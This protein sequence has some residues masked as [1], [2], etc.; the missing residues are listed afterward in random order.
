MQ[1]SVPNF[2][3]GVVP[4]ALRLAQQKA[5]FPR[6]AWVQEGL[7]GVALAICQG[8]WEG[9][10]PRLGQQENADDAD[11]RAAGKDDVVEEI[12]LLVVELHDGSGEHAEASASQDQTDTTAP[13]DSGG[14]LRA[15]EDAQVADGVGGEHA[16]DGEGNG[17]VLVQ[18]ACALYVQMATV[19]PEQVGQAE[20]QQRGQSRDDHEHEKAS[21]PAHQTHGRT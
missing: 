4:A 21:S 8:L 13:D 19:L 18:R 14:N 17:E 20:L 2:H 6:S 1:R 3:S 16:N 5:L 12:A 7:P 10:V 11:E 15:E 9:L